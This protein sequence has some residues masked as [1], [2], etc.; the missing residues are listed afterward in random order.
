MDKP[1]HHI[2]V[3]TSSRLTGQNKGYC[4]QKDSVEIIAAFN[5]EIS[6]RDLEGQVMVTNTGCLGICTLGP[7]VMIYPQQ[8]WYGHV[9]PEDVP[10]ILDALEADSMVERLMI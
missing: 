8:T 4:L 6:D 2:F 5:E 3:C 7:V 10:D 9:T 1:K